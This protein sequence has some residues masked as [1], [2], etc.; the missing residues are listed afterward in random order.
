M[1]MLMDINKTKNDK[2]ASLSDLLNLP[3]RKQ[4]ELTWLNLPAFNCVLI[5]QYL[6]VLERITIAT[7]I[8]K[9]MRE[10]ILNT[11]QCFNDS[12]Q[13]SPTTNLLLESMC[14]SPADTLFNLSDDTQSTSNHMYDCSGKLVITQPPQILYSSGYCNKLTHVITKK[15]THKQKLNTK[16]NDKKNTQNT[17]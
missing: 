7:K 6:P 17:C 1:N 12:I 8:N 9:R 10:I 13:C 4:I 15:L 3:R 14:A 11:P 2:M 5:V 16:K